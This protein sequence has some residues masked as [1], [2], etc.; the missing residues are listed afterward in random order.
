MLSRHTP[1]SAVLGLAVSALVILNGGTAAAQATAQL[2]LQFDF[3]NPG[4]RSLAL[5]G[6]FIGAADDATTAF[7]N[8]AGLA[9][10]ARGEVSGEVRYPSLD[11]PFLQG[12][13]V[14]GTITNIA[15]DLIQGPV[16]GTDVD[17]HVS[18][19]FFS[20][21]LPLAH[22][23]VA[24]YAHELARIENTFFSAG[25]FQQAI[26]AG[27]PTD[28][29]RD[30]PIGG[31]RQ[32]TI[33][34]YGGAVGLRLHDRF[35]LGGG[36][37]VYTFDLEARFARYTFVSDIYSAPDL[38][39]VT[40]TADQDGDD[41]SLGANIGALWSASSRLKVGASYRLGPRFEFTQHDV[42]PL[43]GVDLLREGR[44]KVPDVI[45]VGVEW[46]VSQ[47][48]RVVLDYDRVRY[49]QLKEDFVDIQALASGRPDQLAIDDGNEWH[50][51]VE[52]QFL[53]WP[54]P[55]AVRGGVWFDPDHSIR[56][57][58]TPANDRL[59]ALYSATLPG[60]D[61]LVHYT[62]GGGIVLTSRIELNAGADF[63][64]RTTYVTASAVF[65][66]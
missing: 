10:L 57:E 14:S 15:P 1:H 41:V 19:A 33:R 20:F 13:R 56:Y 42:V 37:S 6:A 2:P 21:V 65:R 34:N 49:S 18:P 53:D 17:T 39:T 45:A 62:A 12:G 3:L 29:V 54:K 63:S 5:G 36:L 16:Y 8:P 47:T 11:T 55:F 58:A 27:V 50:G 9:S 51:G 48:L 25:P 31:S 4:A 61:D 52:Y 64:S 60:G 23:T 24:A 43:S 44:F 28:R 40:A 7:V 35:A 26:F 30:L 66:F 38:G 32:I 22:L 46:R 59:D